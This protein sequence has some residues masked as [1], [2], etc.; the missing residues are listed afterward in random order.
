MSKKFMF[1]LMALCCFAGLAK[2]QNIV[3]VSDCYN[4]A[5]PHDQGFVDM[6]EAEGYTVTRM[7][8]PQSM[9]TSKVDQMN[10]ADLVI[11]GRHG[12]SG[13]Y[14]TDSNEVNMWNSV[15]TPIIN[16]NPHVV[17][18]NRWKWIDFDSVDNNLNDSMH[19]LKTD[20]PIFNYIEIGEDGLINIINSGNSSFV[21][22]SD[23][24]NG[25]LIAETA[26]DSY[27]YIIKWETGQEF[28][29]GSGQYASAPRM[30]FPSAE[31]GGSGD[32]VMNLTAQGQMMFL[33]AVYEMSGA[34]FNRPPLASAGDDIVT[35]VDT[36][37]QLAGSF[38]DDEL[39][40]PSNISIAWS[41][42]S[43]PGVVSF[44]DATVLTPMVSIDASGTYELEIIVSDGDKTASDV[45]I[46][47][48]ADP[49]DNA[50]VSSWSFDSM[51]NLPGAVVTDDTGNSDGV[52]TGA[53]DDLELPSYTEEPNLII[54]GWVGGQALD[55][56]GDS[57]VEVVTDE[58][59]PNVFNLQTGVTLSA[60]IMNDGENFGGLSCIVGKGDHSWRLS[61]D[62]SSSTG[63]HFNCSG[64]T[65]RID[66]ARTGLSDGNW[67][68]VVGTYDAVAKTA[69]L[70]IDGILDTEMEAEGLIAVT[71]APVRVG[72]NSESSTNRI[73]PG[74]ID[75]VR[76]YNYSL[77][78]A[79]VEALAAMA[80]LVPIVDAGENVEYKRNSEGL[81]LV[82]TVV[83]DGMPAA[84]VI[85]W[86]TVSKP[87]GAAD[88]VFT[89]ADAAETVVKFSA[90]GTYVLQLSADDTL[91]VVTDEVEIV[92]TE[93]TCQ[94]V[95]DA[96]LLIM[97]DVDQNCYVDLYDFAAVAANWL[98]CNNP[99]DSNCMWPFN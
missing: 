92:V 87:E 55:F 40:A 41:Q 84:A 33:N 15:T 71:D 37:F 59:D 47:T 93:P 11:V 6:L 62:N 63:V 27:I 66:S 74:A 97:G 25:E 53:E 70:Y 2:S 42:L 65:A 88:P 58:N 32:G 5:E 30:H 61:A 36:E 54:P 83:D 91:A 68:H 72:S 22:I 17:R 50:L 79:E 13:G 20:D 3:W 10:A 57:W 82:G 94:D 19:V 64:T 34:S 75:D 28:Y 99:A 78:M 51:L 67:H 18:N 44:S 73:W 90:P 98:S 7:Q 60:W 31:S 1:V 38:A 26:N 14:A 45:L 16:Q 4:E 8:D 86:S 96:G 49:A 9:N 35:L 69:K 46:V 81:T 21:K 39:P 52:F 85:A 12:N 23:P 89:P 80:P 48:V 95:I 77:S 24:G 29:S 56:F 43:G 76:V